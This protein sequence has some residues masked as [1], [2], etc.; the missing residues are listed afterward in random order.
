MDQAIGIHLLR[1]RR[2]FRLATGLLLCAGFFAAAWGIN[3]AVRPSVSASELVIAEVRRGNVDNTISAAGVVIPVHEEVVSSPGASRVA[4]VLAKPGQQVKQGELLLELDDREIRLALEALKEQLA[5]QENRI[6]VLRQE[7]EQK[8]K[9]TR[10]AIELLEI[11]LQS[12]R[13]LRERNRK[14]RESG[15]VSGQDLLSSELNVQRNEIQLRQQRELIE[16]TRRGTAGAIAAANLQEAILQKQIARQEGLLEQTRVRAPFSGMLTSLVEEEGAS[17]AAGQLVARVSE[18]NNYRVEA[19]VSDFYARQLAPGQEVRVEQN[20]ERFGGRVHT[21]LPEVQNGTIK[22]LVDLEQPHNQHLRNKMRVDVNIVTDRK[23][24]VLVIDSGAAFNGK[25]RQP[26]FA[27]REEGARKTSLTLGASDGK[28]VEVAS[29]A[30]IG[31][32]FIVSDTSAFKDLDS[33]RIT[34]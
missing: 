31:D 29:G 25:G 34:N 30:R 17:V 19:T 12:S 22:L 16:D 9:Q 4:R 23:A 27:V 8:L 33:I 7:M 28:V 26:A 32:R 10:S 5:Q 13:A 15:L 24:G 14:L 18:L 6:V 2:H 1:R 21:I 20:G 11:D 3:R